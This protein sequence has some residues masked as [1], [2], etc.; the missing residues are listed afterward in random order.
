[1]SKKHIRPGEKVPLKLTAAQRALIVNEV[2]CLDQ[3]YEQTI[4][5][6]P[7]VESIMMTLDELDDFAGFVAAEANHC[8]QRAKCRQLDAVFEKIQN[9]LDRFVEV[10][11]RPMPNQMP[12]STFRHRQ[13]RIRDMLLTPQDAELFFK[14]HRSLMWFVN[15]R[16][17]IIPNVAAPEQFAAL[18]PEVRVHVRE[19]LLERLDLI[20]IYVAANPHHLTEEELDVVYSWRDH[21]FGKFFVFRYLKKHAIFLATETP[22]IAYGV[23][24]LT[25]PFDEMIGPYLP[26]WTET[27]LLPFRGQII[28]DGIFNSYNISFGGGIRRALNEDYKQAKQRLGI[29]T[30]LPNAVPADPA[31]QRAKKRRTKP[32]QSMPLTRHA[33]PR[34][35]TTKSGRRPFRLP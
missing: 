29:V 32:Q 12:T 8:D 6:T 4:R 20:E 14:L 5:D 2:T 9:L 30:S 1:M 33:V 24:A 11:E 3:G 7:L 13:F 26:I 34:A 16:Q 35:K 25:Q 23:V 10:V 28:Y 19:A 15:E 18:S 17:Q 31:I 21:V 22:P 27:M